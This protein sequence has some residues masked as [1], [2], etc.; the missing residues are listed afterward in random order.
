MILPSSKS[1]LI[2]R[3]FIHAIRNKTLPINAFDA[4][5]PQDVLDA[6]AL[7]KSFE[8][9]RQEGQH[10]SEDLVWEAGEAG[11]VMRFGLAFLVAQGCGGILSGSAR[12]GQRPIADLVDALLYCGAQVEYLRKEGFPPLRIRPSVLCKRDLILNSGVS[13]QFISAMIMVA[14]L[15]READALTERVPW[16]IS[17]PSD[18]VSSQP[19]LELTVQEMTSAGYPVERLSNAVRYVP[20]MDVPATFVPS[21]FISGGSHSGIGKSLQSGEM[22][23]PAGVGDD[24]VFSRIEGDWSAAS[25]W[26]WRQAVIPL[27]DNLKIQCLSKGSLQAD[28]IILDLLPLLVPG[29]I[30]SVDSDAFAWFGNPDR[31]NPILAPTMPSQGTVPIHAAAIKKQ[32]VWQIRATDFPDMVPSLVIWSVLSGN[33]LDIVGVSHLRYKESDRIHALAFNLDL[34][35]IP[36]EILGTD[37]LAIR[38]P[39]CWKVYSRHFA[40]CHNPTAYP[41]RP[42]PVLRCFGDHRMAMAMSMLVLPDLP[43]PLDEPGVVRKS[44]PGFWE[45]WAKFGYALQPLN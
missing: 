43:I 5:W 41:R 42:I 40:E 18:S 10:H 34:M 32:G 20:A 33:P 28:R 13:S 25:F 22:V 36:H 30:F 1:Q 24:L 37:G 31:P 38:P 17:W 44:Y 3:L 35:G 21:A 6:W 26:I 4:A 45:E 14:P 39:S 8:S 15:L 9:R 7:L 16:M 19:Y 23:F 12:A 29:M 11:T 27:C 2:R